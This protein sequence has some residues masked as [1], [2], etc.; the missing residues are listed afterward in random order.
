M[1]VEEEIAYNESEIERLT[2]EHYSANLLER[3]HTAL[4]HIENNI[5]LHKAEIERLKGAS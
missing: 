5:S 2:R 4:E 1:T 3:G